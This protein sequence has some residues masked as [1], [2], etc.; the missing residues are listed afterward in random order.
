MGTQ[1]IELLAGID[2]LAKVC[3][4][5]CGVPLI[6]V[7]VILLVGSKR[8]WFKPYKETHK[9]ERKRAAKGLGKDIEAL[10][11][12]LQTPPD[13]LR[14]FEPKYRLASISKKRGGR[15]RLDIPDHKTKTLQRTILRK[16][17]RNLKTHSCAMGFD[18]GISIAHNAAVHTGQAVVIKLDIKDFFPATTKERVEQYFR[19]VGWDGECAAL[20]TGLVTHNDGLPQGAPTSP[21]LSNL[22]NYVLDC[23]I[24]RYV[25]KHKGTY[26][27]YADDITVSYPEDWPKYVRGTVQK[28]RRVCRRHGYTVHTRKKL[29]IVRRHQQQRVTGLVV[30]E[31]VQLPREK[32]RWLRAVEHRL[33]T[34]GEASLTE[35]QLAGWEALQQMIDQQ[36]RP[37][38]GS[39]NEGDPE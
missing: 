3:F 39:M 27:R 38:R 9:V 35:E 25:L 21:R 16:L 29:R 32:R 14:N 13:E 37:G 26:T 5:S 30:N 31:K 7:V 36:A 33:S 1:S 8:G 12:R 28:V 17:L 23:Q 24:Q 20:L 15:R 2:P 10:G 22:V 34:T 4:V 6:T 11:H 18:P 19:R